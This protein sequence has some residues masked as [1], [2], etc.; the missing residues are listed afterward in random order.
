[1]SETI[2]CWHLLMLSADASAADEEIIGAIL[3]SSCD[4]KAQPLLAHHSVALLSRKSWP[5]A[6]N[7]AK[8][9]NEHP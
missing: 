2:A 3:T 9:M 6:A 4:L 5:N 1:M 7:I 8:A